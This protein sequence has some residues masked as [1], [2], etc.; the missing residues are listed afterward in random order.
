[1]RHIFLIRRSP[2]RCDLLPL[3]TS[4]RLGLPRFRKAGNVRAFLPLSESQAKINKVNDC[5]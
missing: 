1:M 3:E 2:F 5:F 4:M